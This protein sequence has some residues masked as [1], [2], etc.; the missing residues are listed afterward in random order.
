VHLARGNLQVCAAAERVGDLVVL[1]EGSSRRALGALYDS[2]RQLTKL[3]G[4]VLALAIVLWWWMVRR[5][6]RPVEALRSEVLARADAAVPR[7]DLSI[8][9]RDE[10]GD[11]TAAFNTLIAALGDR[12]RA[13]EAFVADLAHELKNPVATVRACAE[14]LHDAKSADDGTRRMADALDKSAARLDAIVSQLLEVARA[15]AGLPNEPREAVDVAKIAR[16]VAANDT[17]VDVKGADAPALVRGV[18][19]R[20]E[21][22]VRNLVDNGLAFAGQSGW[23]RVRVGTSTGSVVLSVEDSGPGIAKDDLPRVFD[24]FYTTRGAERGTGLGLALVRAIVEAHGGTV[25][26]ESPPGQGARFIVT[27]PAFTRDSHAVR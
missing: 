21:S 18:A 26:A 19:L 27:L 11:L 8:A 7:A 17:R 22:V 20:V 12:T 13:T 1:V 16:A 4:F 10:I 2:R 14:R 3:T 25:L 23:V 24:R 9:R 5:M 6:V 15:E